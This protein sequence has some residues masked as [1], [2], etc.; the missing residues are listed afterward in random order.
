MRKNLLALMLLTVSFS[1][2]SNFVHAQQGDVKIWVSPQGNDDAAGT[3]QNPFA[4]LEKAFSQARNLRSSATDALG[5]VHIVLKGGIYRLDNTLMLTVADSGT[6]D[7][8]TIVEAADGEQPIISGGVPVQGWQDAGAVDGLPDVAQG[9]VW[10][11]PIPAGV[12]DFRQF[13]VNGQKMKRSSTLDDLSLP[14][15][16]SVDK[17]KGVLTVPRIEQTFKHP[18]HLELTIIQDWTMNMLRV[19]TLQNDEYRSKIT[20]LDPES[21]IEFKRPW[22]ILR[23][24]EGSYSNQMFYLANAIEL[25]DQPQEWFY[26][27]ETAKLYYWPRYGETQASVDAVVPAL[28]TLVNIE[29]STTS[30]VSNISFRG[31]TF[32]HT[33]WLRPSQQGHIALQAGQ[34]LYDAYT[35]ESAPGGNVAWVGRPKAAVSI[36]DARFVSFE[37]CV[38]Q[39]LG[40]TALDFVKGAKQMTVRGCAFTDIGGTAVLAGYFGDETFESHMAYNPTDGSVVCDSIIVDNNY[41]AHIAREDWGCVGVGVGYA[42]NVTISHNEIYDTPYSAISVGWGWTK[43]AN[44]MKNNHIRANY[45]HNFSNQMRDS[46]G[47]YTLS[48]Q[49]GSSIEN[50]RLEDVGDPLLNP[51]MWDMRHAQFDLYLDEGSDYFTVRNNWCERGEYS[52]NQNGGHNTWG[53]NGNNVSASIKNAAGLESAYIGVKERGTAPNY[54]PVDS[55]GRDNSAKERIEYVAQNEGFKLGTAIAVDLNN[56]NLLDIVY[57]GGES[58]Q[59]QHGGVRINMGNYDFAATQGIRRLNMS[60]FAAGDLNGDGYMDIVQAGWDFYDCYNALWLNKGNGQLVEKRMATGKKTSPACGIADV[61]NDGLSD[62]FFVG[63]GKDNSFYLQRNNH[64]FGDAVSLLD[65]PDGLSDPSIVY[66]D[67]NNDQS[68]DI[69]VI[70]SKAGGVFT[71]IFYNDGKGNFTEKN[72]GFIEYGTRGAMAYADVNNDGY[73][74]IAIGGQFAGEQWNSTAE[75]GAKIVTVYLNDPKGGFVKQQQ[76]S[77]Y[78]FD[79]VTQPVR[80]CDWDNDGN[81]DLIITGWNMSQGNVSRTDVFLNDG[82]G[83]F[84]KMEAGLPG[85][86]E[87]SIELADFGNS[88]FNDILISGNCNSGWNGYNSDRRL[89]VLCRNIGNKANTAPQAPT[90]LQAELGENGTVTLRW[91]AGSDAETNVNAL[92]YNYYLRDLSTG[93]YMTFPNADIETGKRRVSGMGNAWLNRSWKLRNL[94]DGTYAWSVQ[95]ID[96]AYAGSPFAPEQTFTVTDGAIIIDPVDYPE[97]DA[98]A[99]PEYNAARLQLYQY[100]VELTQME[101]RGIS[102][103]LPVYQQGTK[104]YNQA[105]VTVEQLTEAISNIRSVIADTE[106]AY[107]VGTPATYGIVNPSFE[108]ITSQH[109]SSNAAPFGWTL[110]KNN[111]VVTS[112]STWSWFGA[113]TD[114]NDNDENYAWGIWNGGSYG[115]VELTQTL[116]NLPNGVWKLTARLMNNNTESG[117]LARVFAGNQS[118]LAGGPHNYSS[119]P[120]NENVGFCNAWATSDRDLSNVMT[121]YETVSDGTLQIGVHTNGFFKVDDF[122]LTFLGEDIPTHSIS[123]GENGYA[124]IVTPVPLDFTN[125]SDDIQAFKITSINASRQPV[126]TEITGSVAQGQPLLLSGTPGKEYDLPIALGKY[127]ASM[128]SNKLRVSN[129]SEVIKGN[130][131]TR[132]MLDTRDSNGTG[133]YL[134]ANN[135]EISGNVV[136]LEASAGRTAFLPLPSTMTFIN[137]VKEN[138]QE[139]IIY[140]PS[141]IR[142]NSIPHR[143]LYIIRKGEK[144]YKYYKE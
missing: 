75:Q 16:I 56:D 99:T 54:A 105:E 84:T 139:E 29:G 63:N 7:S 23:A 21:S 67:F 119:L 31:I 2:T 117:N 45:I 65:L 133:F 78:M 79:N 86:S 114:A 20:F 94:P 135:E 46:G 130:G 144:T 13:W 17:A 123:V 10:E 34:F 62:Y 3:E 132:Y 113:N 82:K 91:D 4:T 120:K 48:S 125:K 53:T 96:A 8:P 15:I 87:G 9:H 47:I 74:D 98:S 143:G 1:A 55:I 36:S 40:S 108:N 52:R 101:D 69:C 22:P 126:L 6:P 109:Y 26:D 42:S 38:F 102:G 80:F 77:E 58:F 124:T 112:T 71:R 14:R 140:S 115:N 49:P 51:Q 90:N 43:D 131:S 89:A 107:E 106:T 136:Y 116:T 24:D 76:F 35:D 11:A 81:A 127:T 59:V 50:N 61:N 110:T 138:Q 70:S 19:K 27:T 30:K 57:G 111:S 32:E 12:G 85:V 83:N 122:K 5:A 92:S 66:A 72:V 103:M 142:Y 93:L 121:V 64:T 97:N 95:T 129:L 128:T 44:C 39:H 100:L 37:D 118:M 60:N 88:G 41:I 73:L 18:E 68:V 28:E 25:L 141:G 134:I 137:S 33:T 104:T